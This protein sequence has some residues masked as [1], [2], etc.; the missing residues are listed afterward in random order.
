MILKRT[1]IWN[2]LLF[3]ILTGCSKETEDFG[4]ETS[5]SSEITEPNGSAEDPELEIERFVYNALN[6]IYLYKADV[7]ELANNYFE[8][9]NEKSEYLAGASSPEALFDDLTSKADRFSFITDDYKSLEDRF[10]GVS[11]ATGIKYGIGRI[12]GTNNV[13]G[14]IRYVLPGTS[15]EEAGLVRGDIFTEINGQKLTRSNFSDLIDQ[16]GFTINVG[17]V[18]N[19]EITLTDKT[20]TLSDDPYTE[21]PVFI[22]KVF[23]IEG[24]KIAYLMYNSFTGNFDDELNTVFGEFKTAGVTDLVLDLR[25]NGGGSVESAKDLSS[26]ITGQFQGD[27]FVK[28]QWNAKYQSFYE[29]QNPEALLNRFDDRTRTGEKINSLNLSEVYILTS[30]SSASASELVINGLDPYINVVQVGDH[31]VGKFQASVTLYDSDDFSK[32]GASENHTYALQPLVFKSLNSVGKTD[33]V[34]GL[35]PDI[36]YVEN[37]NEFGNLGDVDEPLLQKAMDAILGRSE[38]NR[39]AIKRIEFEHLGENGMND[40]EFQR[41]YINQLPGLN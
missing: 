3:L 25:Y 17:Q 32:E 11:G 29:T 39:S 16:S 24:R 40:P 27:V 8:N 10:D 7:P 21:N 18:N 37:L 12:S 5:T 38:S 31:T 26:M 36:T 33:Y 20:V 13:F 22:S 23:E 6:E 19:G 14:I 1:L 4:N 41:M 28:E 9:S 2:I 34:N 15:A 35:Q 30:A